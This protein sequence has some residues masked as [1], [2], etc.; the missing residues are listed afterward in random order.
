ME[1]SKEIIESDEDMDFEKNGLYIVIDKRERAIIPHFRALQ[2]KYG[3]PY[4]V[5]HI[6]TGDIA[7]CYRSYI[8]IIIERKTWVDLGSSMKDGRKGNIEKLKKLRSETEC[9]VAYLIEGNP[10]PK[11][12]TKFS[13]IPHKSLRAHL[14][15]LAFR[16]GVHMLY[17]KTGFGTAGRIF[18]LAKNYSTIKPSPLEEIDE[19]LREEKKGGEEKLK[20]KHTASDELILFNMWSAFPYITDKSVNLFVE[21]GYKLKDL[22]QGNIPKKDIA[23][24]KYSSGVMIGLKRATNIIKNSRLEKTHINLLAE[25]PSVT[26]KSAKKILDEI[27]LKKIYETLE[28]IEYEKISQSELFQKIEKIQKTEKSKIGKS[29]TQK[30]LKYL[31][32]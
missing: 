11:S 19:L 16:D 8:L 22:I 7:I 1:D 21:K 26:K 18:E 20:T 32:M 28:K 25:I 3:I 29:T 4:F 17:A 15:H 10:C 6:T 27:E 23:V 5:E 2:S 31:I 12:T 14:D 24:L 13:R 30:I 9:Q